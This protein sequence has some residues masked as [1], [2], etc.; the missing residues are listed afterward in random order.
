[1]N[2]IFNQSEFEHK[3][4]ISVYNNNYYR[5]KKLNYVIYEVCNELPNE[6]ENYYKYF[7]IENEKSIFIGCSMNGFN[8]EEYVTIEFKEHY[9]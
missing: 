5:H 2:L 9:T 8:G 4:E 3:S 7:L 6:D 1:M